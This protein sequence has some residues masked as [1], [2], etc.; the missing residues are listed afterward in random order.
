MAWWLSYYGTPSDYADQPDEQA[1]YWQ[2]CAFA[3]IG[4][5]ARASIA[6]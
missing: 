6:T 4:W 2:R 3:W 5:Q 1:E